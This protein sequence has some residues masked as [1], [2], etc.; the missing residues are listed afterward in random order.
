V[1][2]FYLVE[3]TPGAVGPEDVTVARKLIQDVI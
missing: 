3:I 1:A 2:H